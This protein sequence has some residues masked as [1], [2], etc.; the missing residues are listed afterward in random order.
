M[1]IQKWKDILRW[2][3]SKSVPDDVNCLFPNIEN[4]R[5]LQ[6]LHNTGENIVIDKVDRSV[7]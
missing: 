7:L 6:L 3:V 2:N 4:L 1:A 5:V